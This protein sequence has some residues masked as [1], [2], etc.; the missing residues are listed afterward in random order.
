MFNGGTDTLIAQFNTR[1]L[2]SAPTGDE[3]TL[4]VSGQLFDG[5]SWEGSDTI[6]IIKQGGILL[7]ITNIFQSVTDMFASLFASIADIS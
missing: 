2:V 5:T 4:T 6:R 3:V 7:S 1:D